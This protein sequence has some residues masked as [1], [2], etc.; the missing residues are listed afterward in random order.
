MTARRLRPMLGAQRHIEARIG[1]LLGPAEHH[2]GVSNHDYSL[3]PHSEDRVQLPLP[4]P[5]AQW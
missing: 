2:T 3:I 4:C 1:Q 5:R